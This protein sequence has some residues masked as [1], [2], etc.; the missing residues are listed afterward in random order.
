MKSAHQSGFRQS[1]VGII[2][3]VIE[4]ILGRKNLVCGTFVEGKNGVMASC[5]ADQILWNLHKL[6]AAA[7]KLALVVARQSQVKEVIVAH[8]ARRGTR[9]NPD[10]IDKKVA[11]R[12]HLVPK[13]KDISDA[14]IALRLFNSE[15]VDGLHL[16]LQPTNLRIESEAIVALVQKDGVCLGAFGFEEVK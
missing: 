9:H 8:G 15:A 5:C 1:D 16:V 7:V 6:L 12:N 3:E 4:T 10:V 11:N 14:Q 2:Y 13:L